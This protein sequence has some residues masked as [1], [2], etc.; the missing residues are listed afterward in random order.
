[1]TRD[2]LFTIMASAP[3]PE[4]WQAVLSVAKAGSSLDA[5][6]LTTIEPVCRAPPKTTPRKV[7]ED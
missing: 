5:V 1:L 2:P 7:K 4:V 3:K 6:C